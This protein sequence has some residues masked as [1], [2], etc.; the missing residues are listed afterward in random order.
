[1]VKADFL[2]EVAFALGLAERMFSL[3]AK[4]TSLSDGAGDRKHL[5]E[6]VGAEQRAHRRHLGSWVLCS[7]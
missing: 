7:H 1:M 3:A 2:E 6:G 5:E 4:D